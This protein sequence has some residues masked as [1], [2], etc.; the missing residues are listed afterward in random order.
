[1]AE[2]DGGADHAVTVAFG[3]RP[4]GMEDTVGQF[5]NAVPIRIALSEVLGSK[6]PSF[7][8]LVDLVSREVSTAKKHD[9]L[10]YL[11]ISNAHRKLGLQVPPAQVAITLSPKLSRKECTLYPVEG[12]YDIFFCFLEDDDGVSLG[13]SLFQKGLTFIRL[14]FGFQVIYDPTVFSKSDVLCLK[15]A[16]SSLHASTMA[17]TPLDLLTLPALQT[18][19]PRLL[20]QIDLK[21]IDAIS[22]ARFHVWFEN[23]AA[24]SPDLVALYSGE[25]DRSVTYR[26]LNENANRKAHCQYQYPISFP[27]S[28]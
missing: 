9:R 26:D 28:S 20:P 22:A 16:F 14:T 12:P 18:H 19:V 24:Q 2:P 27:D 6:P 15:E 3:G 4:S 1:M 23:Q 21:S 10:S 13:V 5:A 17:E 11:D 7:E 8:A 25:Q